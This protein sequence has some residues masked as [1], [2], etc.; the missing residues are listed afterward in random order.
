MSNTVNP[1]NDEEYAERMR[2]KNYVYWRENGCCFYCDA[3][4]TFREATMDHIIPKSRGGALEIGNIVIA[5][6]DC[7]YERQ[8]MPA[9]IFLIIKMTELK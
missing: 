9:D 5:C 1:F 8:N 2:V 6:Y 7:N 3:E 4:L